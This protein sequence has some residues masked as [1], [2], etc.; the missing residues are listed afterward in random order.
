MLQCRRQ[1]AFHVIKTSDMN[2]YLYEHRMIAISYHFVSMSYLKYREP[3]FMVHRIRLPVFPRS[4]F[5]VEA[6]RRRDPMSYLVKLW[7]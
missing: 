2:E 5:S 1:K 4:I 6:I 3:P 7:S